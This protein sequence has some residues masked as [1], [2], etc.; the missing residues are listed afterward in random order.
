MLM[1]TSTRVSGA[2]GGITE[3]RKRS[4]AR[5]P[6]GTRSST[7]WNARTSPQPPQGVTPLLPGFAA[8]AAARQV[9]RTGMPM[10]IVVPSI[11]SSGVRTIS[12]DSSS[13]ALAPKNAWRMRSSKSDTEG[14]S[15]ATSSANQSPRPTPRLDAG[16]TPG[17]VRAPPPRVGE[18][19]VGAGGFEKRDR[20]VV[21]RD[22]GMI[23]A[24]QLPVGA[25][26][27]VSARIRRYAQNVVVIAH[28]AARRI[29][30]GTAAPCS[31]R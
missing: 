22:V 18:H 8:A 3:N 13:R 2:P 7:S 30:G 1:S 9:W 23:P 5:T 24:G 19:L 6:A 27:L 28:R 20:A 31:L 4:P 25:L 10:G 11:A 17:V 16:R 14:K 15:I 26:D 21:S 12:A 29:A